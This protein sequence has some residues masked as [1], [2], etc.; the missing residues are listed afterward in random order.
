MI[1]ENRGSVSGSFELI[2]PT[3]LFGAKFSC[4]PS[5]GMILPGAQHRINITFCS[6]IIGEFKENIKWK[7]MV[8]IGVNCL[9]YC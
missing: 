5:Q 6:D 7:I 8:T 2:P 9:Q 3:S 4:S 1:L